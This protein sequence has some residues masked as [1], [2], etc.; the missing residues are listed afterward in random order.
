MKCKRLSAAI[1][2]L[3]MIISLLPTTALAA[4]ENDV[5]SKEYGTI[6]VYLDS[7]TEEDYKNLEG[8]QVRI[9]SEKYHVKDGD[10][11]G[12]RVCGR[13]PTEYWYTTNAAE[14][15]MAK[16]IDSVVLAKNNIGKPSD[17]I[18]IPIEGNTKYKVTVSEGKDILIKYLCIEITKREPH[19]VEYKFS[20]I[21]DVDYPASVTLPVDTD[22]YTETSVV[23]LKQP[24][25]TRVAGK[26]DGKDGTWTFKGW[27]LPD[28][29]TFTD[30]THA[31]FT[32][33]DTNV[34][35]TGTWTFTPDPVYVYFKTVHP[36]D[37]DKQVNDGVTY[38]NN[39]GKNWATLGKL[40]TEQPVSASTDTAVVGKLGK[41]VDKANSKFVE[42]PDNEN[43][44]LKLIEWVE[45]KKDN[46]AAGYGDA[47]VWA[48]H[49][50]G[51]VNV[52]KLSY[53][54]NP[55]DG[56]GKEAVTGMPDSAYYLPNWNA[57]V[58]T[59]DPKLQGYNFGGWYEDSDCKIKAGE[60][61]TVAED[62]I[63]YAKWTSQAQPTADLID[64][65]ITIYHQV[66][67]EA[68]WHGEN[69]GA[70][71]TYNYT[72]TN[73]HT[74][75]K[76]ADAKISYQ[77]TLDMQSLKF[78]DNPKNTDA[79]LSIRAAMKLYNKASL[80]DYMKGED[81]TKFA[82]S[83]VNLHVK[84]SDKL[85][86]SSIDWSKLS[87]ISDWFQLAD[88]CQNGLTKD[89]N[90]YWTI[91]CVIK[92]VKGTNNSPIITLSGITLPLTADAK[93]ALSSDT[94]MPIKSKG[95]IDGTIMISGQAL[96]L[97]GKSKEA[98]AENTAKLK[99]DVPTYTVTYD[100]NGGSGTMT[101]KIVP[102]L[103][104]P[105]LQF[106]QTALPATATPSPAGTCRQMEKARAVR[107]EISSM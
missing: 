5:W 48:W 32:M 33:P 28:G 62:T 87:L 38:N 49:L 6:R 92:D 64:D 10:G 99:L 95:Y 105:Q 44:D 40:T 79:V 104:G 96:K 12:M 58:S 34:T 80:W 22:T 60:K 54:A 94:P 26:K 97:E 78:G 73:A 50:N 55:P 53:N 29:V 72:D 47:P 17:K 11:K 101:D 102:M 7:D 20:G 56:V 15:I 51:K 35:V 75:P 25:Q 84:F 42:H 31:K 52:Y 21:A 57:P 24:A 59:A 85:D 14:G 67:S 61:V 23:D 81:I 74:V 76:A 107:L 106:S 13:I 39:T 65:A 16:D 93:N 98:P 9:M 46:G 66:N 89:S 1:L 69:I 2:S 68:D 30:D 91:P 88:G 103:T 71:M 41:E 8:N 18:S 4:E 77:A 83:E 43:F 36:T 19:T 37:G 3:V 86:T 45:L 100:A 63:L 82:G 27:T 70:N 90:D